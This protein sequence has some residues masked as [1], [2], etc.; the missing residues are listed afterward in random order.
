MQRCRPRSR[1]SPPRDQSSRG[2]ADSSMA[3]KTHRSSSRGSTTTTRTASSRRS[4]NSAD[5]QMNR[6]A[7][8]G[9]VTGIAAIAA[10]ATVAAIAPAVVAIHEARLRSRHYSLPS[11]ALNKPAPGGTLKIHKSREAQTGL[12]KTGV[13]P[14][15]TRWLKS[16]RE[17]GEKKLCR[18]S[19]CLPPAASS[20]GMSRC[21]RAP[22]HVA[23]TLA[24]MPYRCCMAGSGVAAYVA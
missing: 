17:E 3:T 4:S 6:S 10:I 11:C 9:V 8:G 1:R 13:T 7:L 16:G 19:S 12:Y 21:Q 23:A 5:G 15:R 22:Q 18:C 14:P 20:S 2:S 24:C